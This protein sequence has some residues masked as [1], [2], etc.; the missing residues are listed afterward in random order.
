MIKGISSNVK[1]FL[2]SQKKMITQLFAKLNPLMGSASG[3]SSVV[4]RNLAKVDVASSTLV[5][6]SFLLLP[7]KTH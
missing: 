7:F 3:N 4:E 1:Y 2:P 5:S 6:R